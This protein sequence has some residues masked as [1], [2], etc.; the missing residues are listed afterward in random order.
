[1]LACQSPDCAA[2]GM[3]CRL[4][5]QKGVRATYRLIIEQKFLKNDLQIVI[6]GTGDPVL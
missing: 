5:N 2:Y 3:V 6:V 4:T 1:M